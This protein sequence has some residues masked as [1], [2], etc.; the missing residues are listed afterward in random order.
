MSKQ[1]AYFALPG[2][3]RHGGKSVRQALEKIPGVLDVAVNW[4][5]GRVAVDYD[6]TGTDP[7]ALKDGLE[8]AGFAP[9]FTENQNHVM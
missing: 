7:G 9:R 5:D 3:D 6:S 1:S 4:R 8:E 2:L